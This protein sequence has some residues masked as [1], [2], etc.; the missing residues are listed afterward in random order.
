VKLGVGKSLLPI[1]EYSLHF[2]KCMRNAY[3]HFGRKNFQVGGMDYAALLVATT[4]VI[5]DMRQDDSPVI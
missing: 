3:Y 4:H 2:V 5:N 1:Q